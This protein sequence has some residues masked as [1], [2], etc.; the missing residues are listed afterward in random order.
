MALR[1]A[2]RAL[3]LG[4]AELQ[5][6]L[7]EQQDRLASSEGLV[8]QYLVSLY[9]ALGGGWQTRVDQPV[10]SPETQQEMAERTNWG[11]LLD[12]PK[13]STV[14]EAEESDWRWPDW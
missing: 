1:S 10:V 14:E 13:A 12:E 8:V 5:R 9:K 6:R 4:K 3:G 7:A 11:G 2:A